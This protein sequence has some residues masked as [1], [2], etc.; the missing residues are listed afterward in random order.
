MG[1]TPNIETA[2]GLALAWGVYPVVVRPGDKEG[3]TAQIFR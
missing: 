1:A 3:N 2:R